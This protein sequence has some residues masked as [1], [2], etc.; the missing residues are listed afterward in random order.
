MTKHRVVVIGRID[1]GL[2]LKKL[3]KKTGKKV[4]VV[5]HE[6]VIGENLGENEMKEEGR[7]MEDEIPLEVNYHMHDDPQ[8]I[9]DLAMYDHDQGC[10]ISY[11]LTMFNDENVHACSIM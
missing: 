5:V 7:P 9:I 3:Q 4:E 10:E 6:E 11:A 2:V 1:P 8:V